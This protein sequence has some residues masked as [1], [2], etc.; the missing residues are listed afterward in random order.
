MIADLRL[1]QAQALAE[2]LRAR[3]CRVEAI[4]LDLAEATAVFEGI[5]AIEQD[6][7]RLDILVHNAGYFPLTAF[8][9]ITPAV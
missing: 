5:K 1:T 8:A 6:W 9:Q 3:G 7:G 4:A 2:G